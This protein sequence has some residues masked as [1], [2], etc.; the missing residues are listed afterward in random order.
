MGPAAE[1]QWGG[2]LDVNNQA[3]VPVALGGRGNL[4]G[5]YRDVQALFVSANFGWNF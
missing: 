2:T 3:P 5:T 4:V 1:Y